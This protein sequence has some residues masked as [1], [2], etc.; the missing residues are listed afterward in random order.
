M[1][2][3]ESIGLCKLGGY[4]GS[5]PE[6]VASFPSLNLSEN[7]QEDLVA[8]SLPTGVK[9][10]NFSVEKFKNKLLL[11]YVF[12]I[13]SEQ[14]NVRD[15]LA[16]ISIIVDKKRVNVEDLKVLLKFLIDK[17]VS[18]EINLT[19]SM[20]M[21][22]LYDLYDGINFNKKIK[23]RDLTIDIPKIIQKKKLKIF[24]LK[25]DLKGKFF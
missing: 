12:S 3:V 4:T 20:L 16:S 6:I 22:S 19:T 10:N 9:A 5:N 17:M 14:S 8:K 2:I 11:S 25:E 21:E 23:I 7:E 13:K 15:D 24:K 18:E 1:S